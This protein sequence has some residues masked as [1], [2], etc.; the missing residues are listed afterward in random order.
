[1]SITHPFKGVQ[2]F[3]PEIKLSE[4]PETLLSPCFQTLEFPWG[5]IVSALFK[6][7]REFLS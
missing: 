3:S 7:V 1:M 5:A 6:T 4:N 2:I